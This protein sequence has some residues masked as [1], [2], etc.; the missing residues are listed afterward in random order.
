MAHRLLQG[1][2]KDTD[3]DKSQKS[4]LMPR[5]DGG[6]SYISTLTNTFKMPYLEKG[7]TMEKTF[8][9][10]K[11]EKS[12][13]VNTKQFTRPACSQLLW[14]ERLKNMGAPDVTEPIYSTTFSAM[15]PSTS[16]AIYLN[17]SSCTYK[18]ISAW[19][20]PS[21]IPNSAS[22]KEEIHLALEP[23]LS[24]TPVSSKHSQPTFIK[25]RL[26]GLSPQTKS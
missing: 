7:C 10:Q 17:E 21:H 20:V 12:S 2:T 26:K 19:C 8:R 23:T 16:Q 14:S 15:Y 3:K 22:S 6:Y 13:P 4:L 1:P 18:Q 24:F 11:D 5:W 9:V 25:L